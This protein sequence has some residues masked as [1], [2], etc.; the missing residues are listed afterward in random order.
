MSTRTEKRDRLLFVLHLVTDAELLL[1]IV[2]AALARPE[3]R[4]RVR[5]LLTR[6]LTEAA[7]MAVARIRALGLEPELAARAELIGGLAPDL[8]GVRALLTASETSANPHRATHELARRAN[9]A[10]IRTL[11]LQHGFDNIGLTYFDRIHTPA[12]IRFASERILTWGDDRRLHPD[13]LD[14]TRA[15]CVPVGCPKPIPDP[16][17][18]WRGASDGALLVAVF[19]NLHWHRYPPELPQQFLLDLEAVA[20]QRPAV[21]LVLKPHPAGRWLTQRW[22]GRRPEAPNLLVVDPARQADPLE[23]SAALIASA[24]GTITSP[25]TIALDAARAGR[26]VA[27]AGYELE[28]PSYEPLP[29]LRS[30]GDWLA[31]VDELADPQARAR[32]AARSA[33]FVARALLPGDASARVLDAMLG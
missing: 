4:D 9:R 22:R 21:Q 23:D 30:A 24:A 6:E 32:F 5:V 2:A 17:R 3:L 13:V 31:F 28:L 11:T 12:A 33:E 8:A 27:I 16:A 10:G 18:R 15:K 1:P 25:S 19:E 26:P 7:P 29:Q 20:R 14:E